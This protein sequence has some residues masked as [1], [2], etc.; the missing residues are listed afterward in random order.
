MHVSSIRARAVFAAALV[1]LLFGLAPAAAAQDLV[2]VVGKP[3]AYRVSMPAVGWTISTENNVLQVSRED[4]VI[5]VS[6]TDLT[7]LREKPASVSEEDYRRI[8]TQ[9]FMGSDSVMMALMTRVAAKARSLEPDA[10]VEIGTLGG[11]RAAH[12]QDRRMQN[13]EARWHRS[14]ITVKDA[15][16]YMLAFDVPGGNPDAHKDLFERIRQSFVLPDAPPS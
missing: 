8:L 4:A 1:A 15:I 9:N 3:I 10:R 11:Q 16:M 14:Y 7:T 2:P 13:G 5:M 12:V 6:A